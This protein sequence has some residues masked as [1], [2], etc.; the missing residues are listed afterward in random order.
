MVMA[1]TAGLRKGA[2]TLH[3]TFSVGWL[4]ALLAFLALAILGVTSRETHTMKAAYVAMAVTGWFVIVPLSFGSLASGIV[5]ALGTPWGLFR[6]YWILLKAVIA[7]AATALLLA[8]MQPTTR[9]AEEALRGAPDPALQVRLVANA[10]AATFVLLVAVAL[11]VFKPKGRIGE[12][13]PRWL[14]L[15]ALPAAALVAAFGV[16]HRLV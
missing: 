9:L 2:L 5:Q 7:L 4:G 13:V 6:H 16:L 1:M 11:G 14:K 8:H 10:V 3:V 12:D 15:M